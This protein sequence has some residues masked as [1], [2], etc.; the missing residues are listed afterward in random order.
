VLAL[1]LPRV[2][3]G[4]QY[5][6]PTTEPRTR[7]FR[8][9]V[10]GYHFIM[11]SRMLRTLWFFSTFT[12]LCFSAATAG[13]VLFLFQTDGLPPALFGVFM[14]SG[15]VGG[16][17]GSLTASRFKNRLGAG[18]AMAIMNVVSCLAII[19]VGAVHNVWVSAFGFFLSSAAILVWNVL[20]M[21]LRQSAIPGRMLGRVHGTW[22]TLLWGTMPLGSLIG[23]F[24]GRVDLSLPFLIGGGASLIAG[25]VFFRFVS[26][27]PNPEDV[28]NGDIPTTEIGPGGL[29]L[30]D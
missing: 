3:S 6:T 13:I 17:L 22:R 11:A 29:I 26:R 8:Q 16:I 19:L 10:D 28:D 2:A 7:W 1:L 30:E 15:A 5:T 21:S 24:L 25:L 14:L 9:F 18:R 23:G 20:V 12:G 4:K 27:L